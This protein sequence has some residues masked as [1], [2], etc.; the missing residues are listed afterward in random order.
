MRF[1][2][3]FQKPR[4]SVL[5]ERQ[6]ATLTRAHLGHSQIAA[7]LRPGP[8]SPLGSRFF[9]GRHSCWR[10][11]R[12][13]ISNTISWVLQVIW[14]QGHIAA[15]TAVRRAWSLLDILFLHSLTHG[16]VEGS[17]IGR[18]RLRWPPAGCSSKLIRPTWRLKGWIK[19]IVRVLCHPYLQAGPEIACSSFLKRL[20]PS[21]AQRWH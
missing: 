21:T 20:P 8:R 16:Q 13:L 3:K 1:S 12:W 18:P 7:R 4:S 11:A 15:G 14:S 10:F 2:I 6:L 9:C 5:L 17:H 19:T